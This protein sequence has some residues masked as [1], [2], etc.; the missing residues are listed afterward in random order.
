MR[1]PLAWAA[2]I[3][4]AIS[5]ACS[6]VDSP[7]PQ[8]RPTPSP[9]PKPKPRPKPAPNA[10]SCASFHGVSM[11]L[12]GGT[13]TACT[14]RAVTIAH[15]DPRA[16]RWDYHQAY[17]DKG[18]YSGEPVKGNPVAV[19]EMTTLHFEVDGTAVVIREK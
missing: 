7:T 3:G 4:L 6:G 5:L 1:R 14:D 9:S 10:G 15:D 19:R 12:A 11:P 8:P 17:L 18:W 13:I 2:A 16:Q